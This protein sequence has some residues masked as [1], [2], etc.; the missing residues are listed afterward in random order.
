MNQREKARDVI[1]TLES[2][3]FYCDCPDAQGHTTEDG[4][5]EAQAPASKVA[6]NTCKHILALLLSGE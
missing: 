4:T 2:G 3:G 6:P 5:V 1:R